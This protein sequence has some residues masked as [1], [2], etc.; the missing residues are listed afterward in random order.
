MAQFGAWITSQ[1]VRSFD[2]EW[3]TRERPPG[4]HQFLVRVCSLE[5][6][7]L[8]FESHEGAANV[9]RPCHQ[10]VVAGRE[11]RLS[12]VRKSVCRCI[13]A[14]I[15]AEPPGK[16]LRANRSRQ[17]LWAAVAA[18]L[19]SNAGKRECA[20]NRTRREHVGGFRQGQFRLPPEK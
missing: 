18:I 13:N 5:L 10:T 11:A 9:A 12:S 19:S 15:A 4:V 14:W 1:Q 6:A 20:D 8:A 7:L 2:R 3:F 16:R 17:R